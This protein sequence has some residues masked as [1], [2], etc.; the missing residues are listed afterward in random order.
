MMSYRH[1]KL[2]LVMHEIINFKSA[3][4]KTYLI[5]LLLA[6][7]ISINSF[8]Q[9][10]A[11][12]INVVDGKERNYVVY[13]DLKQYRYEFEE[14]GMKGVVI[15]NPDKNETAILLPEMKY[16]H[17]TTCDGIMSMMNDPVQAYIWYKK[18]GEEKTAGTGEINGFNCVKK[19]L[20]QSD[21]KVFTV[22]YAEE[23]NFPVKMINHFSDNTHMELKDI[24][25]WTSDASYF[26]IPE[27]YTEVDERMHTVIPEPPPPES[28]ETKEASIPFEGTV[29]RGTKL[30]I[31]IG[32]SVYHKLAISNETS[33]PAKIIRHLVRNGQE[34]SDDQQGPLKYRSSRLYSGE[35]KTY[36]FDWKEGDIVII[37]A[38][39]GE[40]HIKI[41]PD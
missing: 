5:L 11:K 16:V 27:G 7:L 41:F 29:A 36:T 17:R 14:D 21:V 8:C 28:W 38:C 35:N 4:M 13:S 15:V 18:Q 20:L 3:A 23:L 33:E 22:W 32:Q 40:M 34:L 9:F 25:P 37:E 1:I 24:E 39:E 30:E 19:E 12:M 26:E 2:Y 6:I 10:T 31:K